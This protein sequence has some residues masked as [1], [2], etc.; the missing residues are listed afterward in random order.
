MSEPAYPLRDVSTGGDL[1][2]AL[3]QAAVAL[4]RTRNA[5]EVVRVAITETKRAAGVEAIALY[6][7]DAERDVLLLK[8]STG[9]TLGAAE[10]TRLLSLHE[11]GPV[12]RVIREQEVTTV[13]VA[14][15]PGSPL[16]A[17]FASH[18]FSSVTVVPVAGRHETL[19]VLYLAHREGHALSPEQSALVL[20]IGGLVGV[21]LENASLSER[22]LAQQER[23]RALAGGVLRAREEE[24]RRIAHELHDDAGQILAG[25]HITLD[26]L[27]REVPGQSEIFRKLHDEL[28]RV[29]AQLRRLSREL[30]PTMLD[31]LG[32]VPA[33]EWL[34]RGVTERTGVAVTIHAPEHRFSPSVETA[35]YRI[36]QEALGNA[37]R[38][39]APRRIVV[40]IGLDPAHIRA[41]VRDDGKGFDVAAV[42][43]RRGDR[44][45]GLIGIRE[46]AE[47]LGGTVEI[48][49]SVGQGTELGV[50]IPRDTLE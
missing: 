34:A 19:G 9:P 12:A 4:G 13:P 29:E 5:D 32:L 48:R 41:V 33:L 46:R 2:P 26:E 40:E 8:S 20:A 10:E 43:A 18:G 23:L 36:V 38:H 45:L 24:A 14:E 28:D 7:L 44:G 47:A 15:L 6:V 22:L 49:S 31:D 50:R 25:V 27:V 1:G 30:R 11:A 21:A 37:T 35:L 39:G 16:W 42:W 3:Y 17:A